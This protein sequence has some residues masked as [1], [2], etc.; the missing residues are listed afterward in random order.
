MPVRPYAEIEDI[1]VAMSDAVGVTKK[2]PIGKAE[3][4]E[5]YT[6]RVFKIAPGGHTPKHQHDWEH[7]N[8][9]L[10]G[11]GRLMLDGV[12]RELGEKDFAFVPPNALHQFQN[13]YDEDFEFICIVPN[14]GEK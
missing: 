6:L 12:W 3:G 11:K 1:P 5:G 9:V 8:A 13:P 14:R 2:T 10:S 7:V 4:W